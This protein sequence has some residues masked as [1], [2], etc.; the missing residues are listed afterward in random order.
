MIQRQ[1][2]REP[3]QPAA[4]PDPAQPESRDQD[5]DALDDALE[6]TFPASDPIAAEGPGR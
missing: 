2:E 4:D 5:E 6:G 3:S 1:M